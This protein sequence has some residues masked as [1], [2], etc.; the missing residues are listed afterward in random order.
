MSPEVPGDRPRKPTVQVVTALPTGGARP[1]RQDREA[2]ERGRTRSRALTGAGSHAVQLAGSRTKSKRRPSP[3]RSSSLASRY[4][5]SANGNCNARPTRNV[6]CKASPKG[7][8]PRF[9]RPSNASISTNATGGKNAN[10]AAS[11]GASAGS[12]HQPPTRN[13]R[14]TRSAAVDTAATNGTSCAP[15]AALAKSSY[16]PSGEPKTALASACAAR[17]PASVSGRP[18]SQ[19]PPRLL[20]RRP[21]YARGN[22]SACRSRSRARAA[23][24]CSCGRRSSAAPQGLRPSGETTELRMSVSHP[25]S[26]CPFQHEVLVMTTPLCVE[27]HGRRCSGDEEVTLLRE[28]TSGAGV[29]TAVGSPP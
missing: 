12:D 7:M 22:R 9:R 17:T 29:R 27:Q 26:I 19:E 23:I 6:G 11:V 24:R 1:R 8:T 16:R 14:P 21:A 28:R 3:A 25:P 5:A 4:A 13:A 15:D 10:G 18:R 2:S 20:T